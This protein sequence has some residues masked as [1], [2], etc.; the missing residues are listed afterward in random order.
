MFVWTYTAHIRIQN[1]CTGR[2][3]NAQS[4]PGL[5]LLYILVK[6]LY[7]SSYRDEESYQSERAG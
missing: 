4:A 3:W 7:E 1:S 6:H 5:L 2:D